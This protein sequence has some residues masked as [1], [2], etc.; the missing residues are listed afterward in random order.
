MGIDKKPRVPYM[1]AESLRGP[2]YVFQRELPD[3][4]DVI[5]RR[6]YMDTFICHVMPVTN[7]QIK[8]YRIQ[9]TIVYLRTLIKRRFR[10]VAEDWLSCMIDLHTWN[11]IFLAHPLIKALPNFPWVLITHD[12]SLDPSRMYKD[13][14]EFHSLDND[15]CKDL[16]D[17]GPCKDLKDNEVTDREL[18]SA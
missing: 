18:D 12:R 10:W 3:V 8:E 9:M 16:K 6:R 1:T 7:K 5:A 13:F 4:T 15:P 11:A 2:N 17:N 14:R